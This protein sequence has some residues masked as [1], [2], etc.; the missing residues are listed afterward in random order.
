MDDDYCNNDGWHD[1]VSDGPVNAAVTL[2]GGAQTV[3]AA[4]AW[5][6]VAPPDFAPPIENITTLH[7]VLL[8]VAVDTLG[9]KLPA[10]PSFTRD[11]YPILRGALKMGWVNQMAS[12]HHQ[13]CA[14]IIPP[15]GVDGARAAIFSQLRNPNDLS[16]GDM[17]M[18]YSDTEDENGSITRLQYSRMEK[19]KNGDFINDWTGVPEPA[20]EVTPDGMD[21]A[22]LD[23]CVGAAFF[24]G[25]E[26]SWFL[27]DVYQYSE[28]FRLDQST[29]QAGDVTK[30]M[31]VPW[32]ADFND[33]NAGDGAFAWWPAQRPDQVIPEGGDKHVEWT[34]DLASS[35]EDMVK[36]WH[37][38]G[39]VV[40]REEGFVETERKK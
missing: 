28:P 2:N 21:R 27:R 6:I 40:E 32:Q 14:A 37:Q 24:P 9:L 8:Q 7:D 34:R 31:A 18:L 35:R 13:T 16:G 26:G 36:N 1:D 3:R 33:C 22:A 4:G 11:I 15:P 5:V 29:L 39:F 19:W 30:Q 25:I 10:Q 17:P 12:M 23:G 38:L 20:D